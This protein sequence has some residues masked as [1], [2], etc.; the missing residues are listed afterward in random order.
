MDCCAACRNAVANIEYIERLR[1][2]IE[3]MHKCRATHKTSA[4]VKEEFPDQTTWEGDVEVFSLFGHPK[5]QWCYGWS[6]GEPEQFISVLELP[7]VNSPQ[8]AVKAGI[9]NQTKQTRK[10]K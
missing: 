8:S 5:A 10:E 9:A 2:V 3:A 7:P 4:F 1:V 6:Y